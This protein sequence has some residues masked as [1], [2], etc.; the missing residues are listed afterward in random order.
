MVPYDDSGVSSF[1][2]FIHELS[3]DA[4]TSS[5]AD[6]IS[7]E[8]DNEDSM[9]PASPMSQSSRLSHTSSF[10][11]YDRRLLRVI[12]CLLSWIL[13]PATFLLKV[14][15]ILFESAGLSGTFPKNSP[16][17]H[18]SSSPRLTKKSVQLK[19]HVVQCATDRRRGVVEVPWRFFSVS[20]WFFCF[21]FLLCCL[22]F[23]FL[24]KLSSM[25]IQFLLCDLMLSRISS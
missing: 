15:L 22:S 10:S 13:W 4:E 3:V 16:K 14:P 5:T 7:M 6:S 9:F 20:C 24:G 1:N 19:D 8:E 18:Q 11:R 21:H 12:K 2:K 23:S 17:G 25:K